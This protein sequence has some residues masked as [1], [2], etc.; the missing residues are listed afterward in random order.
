MRSQ[1]RGPTACSLRMCVLVLLLSASPK[2]TVENFMPHQLQNRV[3]FITKWILGRKF[4]HAEIGSILLVS[5]NLSWKDSCLTNCDHGF[6]F[7]LL[8]FYGAV[9]H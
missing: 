4:S 2:C 5:P 8:P 7:S 6:H 9:F 1:F 3:P